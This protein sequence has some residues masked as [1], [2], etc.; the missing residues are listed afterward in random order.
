ME[1]EADKPTFNAFERFLYWFFIPVV[2][3]TVLLGALLSLFDYDIINQALKIG[4]KVP[5]LSAI[6]PDPKQDAS[7]VAEN[8]SVPAAAEQTAEEETAASQEAIRQLQQQL[9]AKQAELSGAVASSEQKD[10][11]IKDLQAK[12]AAEQELAVVEA[13]SD[14]EYQALIAQTADMYAKMSPSKAAPI[15]ENLTLK[16]QVLILSAMKVDDRVRV[17]E[18]M[19]PKMAA[20]ASIYLKDLTP[21]KDRQIAALQERLKLG[22]ASPAP[23]ATASSMT[24]AELG[25]TFANMTPKSAAVLLIEMYKTSPAKVT[26]IL[27]SME[28]AARSKVM[29][30][31]SDTSKETAVSI[32]SSLAQ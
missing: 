12:L 31:I 18:K 11:E 9:E 8:K 28:T 29:T 26:E 30:S 1:T 27:N 4:D 25:Q 32:A 19:N 13:K 21:A 17:L 5:G 2:F 20:E 15:M 22:E 3:T 14:E 16:E 10:Q 6:L 23:A 24:K 7:A